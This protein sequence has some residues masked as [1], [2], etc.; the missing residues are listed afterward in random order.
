MYAHPSDHES[1]DHDGASS[2]FTPEASSGTAPRSRHDSPRYSVAPDSPEA[3][4][5]RMSA[6]R[7]N[8]H[9]NL[10]AVVGQAKAV[11]NWRYLLQLNPLLSTGVAAVCGYLLVPRKIQV[12]HPHPDDLARLAKQQ[13]IVVQPQQD[14]KAK[15]T[16]T[17]RPMVNFLAGAL[18]RT[19]LTS[20]GS[21]L[22]R[23][24]AEGGA[25]NDGLAALIKRHTDKQFHRPESSHRDASMRGQQEYSKHPGKP[26]PR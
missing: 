10:G 13:R 3:I 6:V 22:G 4:A 25:A 21:E 15:R 24:W 26:V 7:C 11:T 9:E 12:M 19:A 5:E 1:D 23:V 2:G 16:G 14:Q 18:L 17:V 8:L 20:V